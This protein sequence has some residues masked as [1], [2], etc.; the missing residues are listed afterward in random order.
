[1]RRIG[2]VG[3]GFIGTV[4]S[5]ALAMLV[6]AGLVDACVTA[7]YDSDAER[8]AN[9]ARQH[10]GAVA[11]ASVED[12][13]DRVDLVWV[14]T[15]TAAHAAVVGQAVERG[16]AV[17]CEKPLA[18]T[19]DECAHVAG[20]LTTVP[21]QVGLVLRYAP[22]FTAA[23]ALVHDGRYGRHLATL[24][25]DDQYLPTQGIY[26]S[27]WR[28]DVTLAGGGTLLEHSIHD[29]DLLRWLHGEPAEVS[30]RVH[31]GAGLAGID[32]TA[33]LTF[34]FADGSTAGLVSVWHQVLSRPSTRR[35]E[36]FCE[37]AVLWADDDHLGPLHV[38][39]SAGPEIVETELPAW[40]DRCRG[41]AELVVPLMMY[42][43]PAKAFLDALDAG[44]PGRPDAA[45]ALAAHRL[46]E[47]AYRSSAA[48][49]HPVATD[50]L[51]LP[52]PAPRRP[53]R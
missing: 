41:P 15:W 19:W 33:N 25:R 17:F 18:P 12:L 38:E 9:T 40:A 1:M 50:T 31:A 32:D 35:L 42:A 13:L 10:P 46:V 28:G 27:T 26:G 11:V 49:G 4:H 45:T 39:T 22:V 29:V 34:A 23:A 53:P 47:L 16:L 24:M 43:T 44:S 7:T 5:Y 51:A 14:C 30:A 52:V 37:D 8:A 3:C 6:E 2:I 21:H 48:G 36:I 20:L